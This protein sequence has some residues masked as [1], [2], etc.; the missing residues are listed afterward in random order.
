MHGAET[1]IPGRFAL[2][3]GEWP[4]RIEALDR[5]A[6]AHSRGIMTGGSIIAI[7]GA[8]LALLAPLVFPFITI[9]EE[10]VVLR[11]FHTSTGLASLGLALAT[12]AIGAYIYKKRTRSAGWA[13]SVLSLGQI[14]LMAMTYANVWNLVPC[15]SMGLALCDPATGGLIDQSLVTLDSG[16]VFVILASVLSFFGGLVC[17]SA[18]AEYKKDE[19]FLRVMLTW[20]GHIVLERVLFQPTP[21]TVGESDSNTFQLAAGGLQAHTLFKPIAADKYVLDVPKGLSGKVVVGG[22]QKD[23]EGISNTEISRNDQG[24]LSFDNGVDLVFQFTGAESGVLASEPGRDVGLAVSFSAVGAVMLVLM[25]AMIGGLNDSKRNKAEEQLEAKNRE[26]IEISL[27]DQMPPTDEPK[28]EG[29]EDEKTAKKAAN[30]EGKFGDP[31]KDPNKQSKVPKME[32]KMTDKIDVKNLGIAKVLA[33][34]QAGALGQIMAGDTGALNSKMAVAMNGEG[35]EL[36]IGSGSGGMG[37][38]GTG[39]GGGGDGMGR[40]HGLGNIDTGAGTGRNANIGIGR[41]STKKVAKLN[42]A[43]GS[44][45]GGCDKG[46]IAKNVR[47]RAS[48]LRQCY[49]IQL[50]SKPDLSGKLTVQWTINGE[51]SVTGQ[52]LVDDTM[53]NNSVSDCVLRAISHI[54]FMKPEAGICV[55]QWPFVFNPG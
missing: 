3:T 52:K 43:Q 41:K 13:I 29:D 34:A 21:V 51:G 54:R 47:A 33:G 5:L 22:A 42:I 23:A 39:S 36:T 17:V 48:S 27:E 40:I 55:I 26:L 10:E 46:D 50:M 19:R 38:R 32:G 4:T 24:V 30:E 28:P 8:L 45:T 2:A 12:L 31:D 37:F 25:A 7:I 14:G 15:Q 1:S 11:S 20:N 6:G 18:H 9:D 35:S 44:S 49:E 16:M 53:K